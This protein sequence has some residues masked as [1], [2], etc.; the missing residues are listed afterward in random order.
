VLER[1]IDGRLCPAG[2]LSDHETRSEARR[3]TSD[4]SDPPV[5]HDRDAQLEAALIAEFLARKGQTLETLRNL[6]P[7]QALTLLK[8]ASSYASGRLAEIES[9]AHLQHDLHGTPDK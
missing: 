6:P 2:F 7:D 3:M 9:R 5:V 8:E 1:P 4:P